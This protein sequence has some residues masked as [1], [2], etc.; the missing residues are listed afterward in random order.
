MTEKQGGGRQRCFVRGA[1]SYLQPAGSRSP[2]GRETTKV[3]KGSFTI[4]VVP[5]GIPGMKK[6]ALV[7]KGGKSEQ[8]GCGRL[9]KGSCGHNE[10]MSITMKIQLRRLQP[11]LS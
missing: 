8:E 4:A 3:R 6:R 1:F 2:P 11:R 5:P 10:M 7:E 9:A